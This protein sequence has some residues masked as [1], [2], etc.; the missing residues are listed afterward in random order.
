MTNKPK[1]AAPSFDLL[2]M[3][4]LKRRKK[5][6]SKYATIHQR[7]MAASI[8]SLIILMVFAP[9][10]DMVVL[11]YFPLRPFDMQAVDAQIN[12]GG[13]ATQALQ[14]FF[15]N[16]QESGVFRRWWINSSLQFAVYFLMSAVCWHFWSATPGKMIARI[17]VVDA[18]TEQPI[19]LKQILLRIF[20]YCMVIC[21]GTLGFFWAGFDKRHQG[22]HDK[23]AGTVLLHQP[24]SFTQ[25]LEWAKGFLPK[26]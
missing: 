13:S 4:G 25:L 16:S 23:I 7:M 24:L 21:T 12:S 19:S 17:K 1:P 18:V 14:V 3:T 5:P 11:H 6:V 9:L 22:I 10:M 2:R 8:D 26:R 20:G 15:Q